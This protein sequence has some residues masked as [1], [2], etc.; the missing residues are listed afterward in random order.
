M[1]EFIKTLSEEVLEETQ[2]ED[3]KP[4]TIFR[5]LDEWDSMCVMLIIGLADS[6]FGKPITGEDI[7]KCVTIKDLFNL[8]S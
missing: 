5:D 4:D 8:V 6:N 7:S 2:L 1:N 3:I